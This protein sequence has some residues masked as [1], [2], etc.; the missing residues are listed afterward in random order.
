MAGP[1]L[2]S[3]LQQAVVKVQNGTAP[4]DGDHG[5]FMQTAKDGQGAVIPKLSS[6]GSL[7]AQVMVRHINQCLYDNFE[8]SSAVHKVCRRGS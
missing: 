4:A 2:R 3:W 8:A 5:P 1:Q 7:I 6:E